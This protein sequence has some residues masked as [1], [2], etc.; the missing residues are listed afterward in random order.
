[1]KI[2]NV[3]EKETVHRVAKILMNLQRQSGRSGEKWHGYVKSHVSDE[4]NAMA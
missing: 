4:C 2:I 3:R 1:M